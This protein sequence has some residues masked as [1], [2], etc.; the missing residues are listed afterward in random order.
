MV[1]VGHIIFQGWAPLLRTAIGTTI[2]YIALVVLLRLAG[3]RTLAKWYAFDLIVTVA[4]GSTFANSVLSGDISVA[5]SLV[6]FVILIG[7]QFIIAF[8]VAHWS[9]LRV[10]VNPQPTLL[11]HQ[12]ELVREA[13]RSQRVAEADVRAAVRQHGIDRLED[14]GAVVLEADGTFSVIRQLGSEASALADIPELGGSNA[15]NR[16]D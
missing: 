6:G 2:T 10:I 12:G 8:A 5:Q 16:S 15:A 1:D 14:V 11:V 4:L 13:M 7:L 3:P 9:P